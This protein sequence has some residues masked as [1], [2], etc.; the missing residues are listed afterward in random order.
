MHKSK[1]VFAH[2]C[3]KCGSRQTKLKWSKQNAQFLLLRTL[4]VIGGIV[5][6]GSF[7]RI[8]SDC[9][10]EFTPKRSIFGPCRTRKISRKLTSGKLD[11][12][13]KPKFLTTGKLPFPL[14]RGYSSGVLRKA[15]KIVVGVFLAAILFPFA[16]AL[17]AA[18][19]WAAQS[20]FL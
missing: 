9:N 1:P 7:D 13:T 17:A 8:C 11:S 6:G 14:Q 12:Q 3:P 4:H 5:G 19:F 15:L 18:V 10:H 20:I 2:K 16:A